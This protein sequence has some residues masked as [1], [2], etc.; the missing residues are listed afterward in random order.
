MYPLRDVCRINLFKYVS[1]KGCLTWEEKKDK[2]YVYNQG[3][4]TIWLYWHDNWLSLFFYLFKEKENRRPDGP[5]NLQHI[6]SNSMS[7]ASLP[8]RYQSVFTEGTPLTSFGVRN[9]DNQLR[10]HSVRRVLFSLIMD[11]VSFFS[12]TYSYSTTTSST[13]T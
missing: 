1:V 6:T 13:P 2:R 12:A 4:T 8:K 5:L 7:N 9:N 3:M 10:S 11:F